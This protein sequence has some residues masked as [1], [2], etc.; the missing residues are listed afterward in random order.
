[1]FTLSCAGGWIKTS[2]EDSYAAAVKLGFKAIEHLGWKDVDLKKARAAIDASGCALSAI[3]VQ[4]HDEK[5]QELVGWGHGIVFEDAYEPF[6][7]AMGETVEAAK[8]LACKNIIV[9]TGNE[10]SDVSRP[11]QRNNIIKALKG[12]AKVV[13]DTDITLVLEPLNILVDHAG[14]YLTTTAEGVDI[15]KTVN[16]PK[17]KLLYD[18]YHQQITEGNLISN[19]RANIQHIGHIHLGDVPGRN[20]PGSG[21]INYKN[22]LAA[23]A[24]TGYN[25]YVALECGLTEDVETVCKK[26][27]AMM[28]K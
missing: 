4:S 17:V 22:V 18:V 25:N 7:A 19:I 12:A 8:A 21:E 27:W 28:P 6:I 13:E 20:E 24:N 15:L 3:V 23:I 5:R 9:T 1:M 26:V 10:R 11:V 16:H 2:Y 14:Y